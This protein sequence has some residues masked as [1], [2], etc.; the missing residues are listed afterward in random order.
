MSSMRSQEF[1]ALIVM[2]GPPPR[3]SPRSAGGGRSPPGP[4]PRGAGGGE[5][6][7]QPS[8][9]GAGEGR[10]ASAG[11]GLEEAFE[12]PRADRVL[13]LPHGLGLDLADALARHLEDPA[14][15]LER[16]G[17][18]VADAV[19]ELD[20][21]ALAEGERLED[22]LELV[23]EHLVGR[24][25]DGA[26]GGLVLD[27]VAE[28]PVVAL[29]YRTIERDRVLRDLHDPAAL[30][31]RDLELGRELLDRRLAAHLLDELLRDIP[32][33]G[34]R[35]DHVDRDTDR[36]RLIGDREIGRAHV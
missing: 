27:E 4:S 33:L 12:H 20:D 3:P 9:R 26:L 19:A 10:A 17:V 34:H 8:P 5:S 21:L 32:E 30:G 24:G 6:A 18:A 1:R 13:E 23:L 31:D 36:A 2:R 11:T 14:D 25:V 22:L 28:E 35:L 7:A 15:L 29:S 16:V